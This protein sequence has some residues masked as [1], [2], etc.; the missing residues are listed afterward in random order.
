MRPTAR[1]SFLVPSL[2]ASLLLGACSQDGPGSP[3]SSASGP[4]AAA[5][6]PAAASASASASAE[7][8]EELTAEL[9]IEASSLAKKGDALTSAS[10]ALYNALGK[11]THTTHSRMVWGVTTK[12]S[13]TVLR[14]EHEGSSIADV[15]PAATHARSSTAEFEDCWLYLDRTPPDRDPNAA[16]PVDGKVYGVA[17]F[18]EGIDAAKSKW[19]GKK[20]RVRG[21]VLGVV[22]SGPST[23][24]IKLASMNVADEKDD[25]KRMGVQVTQDVAAAPKDG[26]K[27]VVVA[28]GVVAKMGRSIDEARVVK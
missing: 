28:E 24:D 11:P 2:V 1:L 22:R 20:V 12:D 27:V 14:V 3:S 6:A 10:A 17:E 9:L 5:S 16:G 26:Q 19:V 13:C 4:S 15:F 21:R 7:A 23:E 8:P 18:L 25:T